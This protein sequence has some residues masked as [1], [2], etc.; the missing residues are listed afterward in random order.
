MKYIKIKPNKN[1]KTF[2][3]NKNKK[4]ITPIKIIKFSYIA[5]AMQLMKTK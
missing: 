5:V 2:K 1:K 3:P 4:L